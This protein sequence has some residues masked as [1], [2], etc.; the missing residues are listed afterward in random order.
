MNTIEASAT[1]FLSYCRYQKNLSPK[2]LKSYQI[3][4]RQFTTFLTINSHPHE[5]NSIDKHLLRG[6]L[7]HISTLKPK[8]VKRKIATIKSLFNFLE[9]EDKIVINPFRKMKIQIREPRNLPNVMNICEVEQIIKSAYKAK[10]NEKNRFSYSYAERVRNIAVIELLFATGIRVSELSSLKVD[11][12]DVTTGQVKVKGKGNKER[13]IQVCN[14]ESL[15]ALKDYNKLFYRKIRACE[16]Y[17]FI[18]RLNRRLSEQSIRLLVKQN[19]EKAG[20]ERRITPH[21]FRH[22]FATLL[23]EEDVDIKYIQSLLGHSSIMTTQ[24]YTHVNKEKQKQIL[25]KQHPRKNFKV[26]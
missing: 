14:P 26:I 10:S 19:A 25:L 12:I 21:V 22:S 20:L 5:I 13:I 9:Y 8:T 6:Y 11:C 17:F 4:L 24:I 7:Q 16:G 15:K 23:L 2:T 1:D 18:N 3:D